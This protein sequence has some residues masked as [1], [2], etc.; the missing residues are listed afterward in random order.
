MTVEHVIQMFID[1][2]RVHTALVEAARWGEIG[3]LTE[4]LDQGVPIEA[5]SETGSTALMLAA[6][7]GQ[8]DVVKLLLGRGADVNARDD[9]RG[10][11][12][13]MWC[14]AALHSEKVYLTIVRM[15]IDAGAKVDVAAND[16]RAAIDFARTR[17]SQA[18]LDVLESAGV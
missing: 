7:G 2:G 16:G 17:E 6:S 11:T 12:A 13:L 5:R 9:N 15:L 3:M 4:L 14:L 10:R 8:T 1:A 18:L